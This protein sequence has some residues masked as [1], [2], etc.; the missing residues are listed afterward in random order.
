M[1][2]KI[3][4]IGLFFLMLYG[5][6]NTS[7]GYQTEQLRYA[8]HDLVVD[9]NVNFWRSLGPHQN[10]ILL[11]E[12]SNTFLQSLLEFIGQTRSLSLNFF[13]R[14]D[15][16][17]R[18][19]EVQGQAHNLD[20]MDDIH[21]LRAYS[22]ED[23]SK[24]AQDI[25]RLAVQDGLTNIASFINERCVLSDKTRSLSLGYV[26][27][28]HILFYNPESELSTGGFEQIGVGEQ[29]C[30]SFCLINVTGFISQAFSD[31]LTPEYLRQL[32]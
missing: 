1:F 24:T 2:K 30:S 22:R 26:E 16:T 6:L 5:G 32:H 7:F 25:I 13:V 17:G 18:P 9:V 14:S 27:N 4:L 29:E 19:W 12:Q 21:L 8:C 10:N 11:P 31:G 20:F 28:S 3:K 23:Y 15:Y